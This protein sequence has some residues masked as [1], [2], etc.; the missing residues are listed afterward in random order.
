MHY[1]T[2]WSPNASP[3]RVPTYTP[4]LHSWLPFLWLSSLLQAGDPEETIHEDHQESCGNPGGY[5]VRAK[6]NLGTLEK[7]A[8]PPYR[9]AAKMGMESV[10]ALAYYLSVTD[11]ATGTCSSGSGW[12]LHPCF[13]LCVSGEAIWWDIGKWSM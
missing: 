1:P 4:S 9:K 10:K 12:I 7:V 8:V 2:Q 13:C 11:M 6:H 5:Y 3:A